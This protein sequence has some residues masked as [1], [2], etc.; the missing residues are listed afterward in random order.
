VKEAAVIGVAHPR[1]SERPL[2]AVV[3]R[4][5]CEVTVEAL[6]E[7]LAGRF[8]KFWLPDAVVFVAEIP[9]TSTGKFKKSEL[10]QAYAD[11][12]TR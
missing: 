12:F 10:R 11:H 5:G 3:L 6:R 7:H 1:W 8:P 9:R 4:P 2:A